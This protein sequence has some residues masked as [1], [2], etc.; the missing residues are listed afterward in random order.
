MI[1]SIQR[2]FLMKT[3]KEKEFTKNENIINQFFETHKDSFFSK[4]ST[5]ELKNKDFLEKS[6]SLLENLKSYIDLHKQLKK[7]KDKNKS[8]KIFWMFSVDSPFDLWI[9]IQ[10]SDI[11]WFNWIFLLTSNKE[12]IEESEWEN[13]DCFYT[14]EKIPNKDYNFLIQKTEAWINKYFPDLA[15]MKIGYDS[16]AQKNEEDKFKNLSFKIKSEID[17]GKFKE[18]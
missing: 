9:D 17:L 1:T 2:E 16:E 12:D 14:E 8:F 15:G 13:F 5:L 18:F 10:S 7:I 3:L 11:K 6:S 4:D